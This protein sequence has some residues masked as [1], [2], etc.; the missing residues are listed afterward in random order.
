M[1]DAGEYDFII[2]GAGSAGCVV[3]ARLSESGRHKVLLVEAGPEDK[4]FWIH[5]PLGYA[6]VFTDAR[7]NWM[8]ESE[9]EP[10]LYDRTMYQ[11]RGKVLGGTSSINGMIYIRGNREDYNGWRASGCGG[12]GWDDVLPYFRKAEGP[13]GLK[14]T[15]NPVKHELAE[16]VLRAAQQRWIAIHSRLQQRSTGGGWLLPLQYLQG[17]SVERRQGLFGAGAHAK[18]PAYRHWRSCFTRVGA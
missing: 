4:H 2:V 15:S 18:E 5:V 17:P 13:D 9:P 14:V 7:I 6:N 12:W 1:Q 11:P 16:A 10:R 3:A 8:L